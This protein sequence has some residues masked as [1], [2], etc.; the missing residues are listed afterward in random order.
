MLILSADRFW[1]IATSGS[2]VLELGCFDIDC[3]A[4]FDAIDEA[5]QKYSIV[6]EDY[7]MS[8][9]SQ[10]VIKPNVKVTKNG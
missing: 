10:A 1:G 8:C 3:P 6:A 5:G 7:A 4:E 2:Q 9:Q